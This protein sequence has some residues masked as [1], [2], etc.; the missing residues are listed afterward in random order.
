MLPG[1]QFPISSSS[2]GLP[3]KQLLFVPLMVTSADPF[4]VAWLLRFSCSGEAAASGN[5]LT[6]LLFSTGL[7]P[8]LSS[9]P[10]E[11]LLADASFLHCLSPC[12]CACEGSPQ[13]N[14]HS[15]WWTWSRDKGRK[16]RRWLGLSQ[17]T[18]AGPLLWKR[19]PRI[20]PKMGWP[21]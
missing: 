10:R 1:K 2:L 17:A 20:S 5:E 9:A 8:L 13:A 18:A 4:P 14:Q 11:L 19:P 3:S 15:P 16:L 6:L 7:P 21:G 12:S